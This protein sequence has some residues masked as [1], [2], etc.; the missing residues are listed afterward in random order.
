MVGVLHPVNFG[1]IFKDF[2]IEKKI[3]KQ[4]Q[5]MINIDGMCIMGRTL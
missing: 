3:S 4:A 1:A 2:M 5:P